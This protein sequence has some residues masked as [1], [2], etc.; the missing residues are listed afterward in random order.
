MSV[1]SYYLVKGLL[2][3]GGLFAFLGWQYWDVSRDIRRAKAKEASES[4][5]HSEG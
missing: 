3:F 1:D 5:G 2:V 4:A